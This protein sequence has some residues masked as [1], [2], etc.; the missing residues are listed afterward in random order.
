MAKYHIKNN[1]LLHFSIRSP[2]QLCSS[3]S[4]ER[5]GNPICMALPVLHNG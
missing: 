5:F 2:L 4:V 1:K 3:C